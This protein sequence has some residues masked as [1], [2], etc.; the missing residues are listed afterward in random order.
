[1]FLYKNEACHTYRLVIFHTW[2]GQVSSKCITDVTD[3]CV[4]LRVMFLYK[5]ESCHTHRWVISHTWIGQV[6]SKF[7]TDVTDSCVCLRVMFLYKKE[8][9]HTHEK[10]ISHTWIG[11]VSSKYTADMTDLWPI[12]MS[13]FVSSATH[14]NAQMFVT[15]VPYETE[16]CHTYE[17]VMSHTDVNDFCVCL[18]GA[19]H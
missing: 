10:F 9:C 17:W 7:T 5:N 8:V 12:Y 1:M 2:I 3:S 15:R 19:T 11:R 4:C 16:L 14:Y 6:S 13:A 18:R